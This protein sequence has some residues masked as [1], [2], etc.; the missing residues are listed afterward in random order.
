MQ[1][2]S[3]A[4]FTGSEWASAVEWA[5]TERMPISRHVLKMRSAI[6]PRL[7]I[8]TLWNTD[9]FGFGRGRHAPPRSLR[10][11]VQDA[12][13]RCSLPARIDE[14]QGLPVLDGLTVLDEDL[15]DAACHLRVDL[16]HELHGLDDANDLALFDEVSLVHERGHVGS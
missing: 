11:L 13:H 14:E 3:S 4:S 8:R 9:P 1:I 6:S 16:V 15:L 12:G 7:A 5:M 10:D 2:D